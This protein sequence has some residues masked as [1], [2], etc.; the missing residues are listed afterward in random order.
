M[1]TTDDEG[2][3]RRPPGRTDSDRRADGDPDPREAGAADPAATADS[4]PRGRPAGGSSPGTPRD[5]R[6]S[7]V[8]RVVA[9]ADRPDRCTL[10]PPDLTGH[11]QTTTWLSADRELL[12]DLRSCR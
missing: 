3:P 11:E 1:V 5:D 7:L 2:S 6:S 8:H 9:Y 4:D 10:S 12:V